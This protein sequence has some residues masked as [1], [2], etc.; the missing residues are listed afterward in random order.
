M[1]KAIFCLLILLGLPAF[2]FAQE[3]SNPDIETDWDD[4]TA[5]PYVRG[6]QSFII[7]LGVSF[8]TVF[9][10][11]DGEQFVHNITPPIGGTGSLVYS[12]YLGPYFFVGAEASLLFLPTLRKDTIF[13]VPL[14]VR[15]GTQL[16]FGRF[17]FPIFLSFG[18]VFQRLLDYGYYGIYA[19]AGFCAFFKATTDWSF[20]VTSS[21]GFFPQWPEDPMKHV[22][23]N[24][25]DV[26]LSA[27]YH[28]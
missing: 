21:W 20:G 27:R 1:H 22:Y 14:G 25:V 26:T 7:S 17:E 23:A 11:G 4:F 8:P 5:D 28:F 3:D 19:K 18:M 2:L 12:Y 6:D 15:V 24:F 9:L 13:I 16:I 10:N